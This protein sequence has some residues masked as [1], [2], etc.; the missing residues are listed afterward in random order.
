MS[1]EEILK[2]VKTN[3]QDKYDLSFIED[4]NVNEKIKVICRVH[5]EFYPRLDHFLNGSGCPYCSGKIRGT[6]EKFKERAMLLHNGK[7]EYLDTNYI[8]AHTK[9][10]IKCPIHGE[11]WQTPTNHLNGN[12][13]PKCKAEEISKKLSSSLDTF[14]N[15]AKLVHG[16]KYDYS[17]VEYVNNHTKVC[18]VCPIH[19]EFWQTPMCHLSG[20]GCKFCN[21]SHLEKEIRNL[22]S[23]NNICYEY[24]WHL[25][26]SKYYS[27]DFYLP[28]YN[29]GI[30]CQGG[31]H[32]EPVEHF[33][34]EREF[35]I[36]KERDERKRVLCSENG[37]RLL[38]YSNIEGKGC[39]T[40]KS[41][42]ME[43]IKKGEPR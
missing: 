18:I 34:G 22:L 41:V 33:G 37:V 25:P 10:R 35:E 7:Y 9:I 31:Q 14:I 23:E 38:Y 28:K 19:G 21:E 30:E 4:S 1:R 43:N 3:G 42:L 11:F 8:N 5:G 26:W 40:D 39:I 20:K 27:L 17:K 2:R 12:G 29:V 6:F 13:C 32:F 16:D 15:K 36:V 24:Q